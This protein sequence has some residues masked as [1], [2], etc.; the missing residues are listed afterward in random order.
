[1]PVRNAGGGDRRI[2]R[3]S[4]QPTTNTRQF[5]VTSHDYQNREMPGQF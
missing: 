2:Y 4:V 5:S 3:Y 1:M